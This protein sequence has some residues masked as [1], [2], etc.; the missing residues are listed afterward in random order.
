MT[1]EVLKLALEAQE[2]MKLSRDY[3]RLPGYPLSDA[4]RQM[5]KSTAALRE[6]LAQ[7]VQPDNTSKL[8][9]E[10]RAI[11][12][13]GSESFTHTDAVQY[14]KDNLASEKWALEDTAHRPGGLPQPDATLISEGTMPDHPEDS[15]DMVAQQDAKSHLQA[16]AD[17]GQLQE[18]EPVAWQWLD[19]ATFRKKIPPTGESE[20]WNPLYASPPKRQPLT[21]KQIEALMNA[22]LNDWDWQA[23]ARAI[24]LHHDIGDKT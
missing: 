16:V 22:C 21:D 6:A 13:S 2:R 20:C 18:R 14:L 17:F 4:D 11:I 9:E 15:L 1:R 19:T 23:F 8:Y 24:E 5:E 10:L 12:D 7:P 3:A